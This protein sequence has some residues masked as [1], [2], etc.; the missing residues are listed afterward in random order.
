MKKAILVLPLLALLP[1]SAGTWEVGAFIGQQALKSGTSTYIG[2]ASTTTYSYDSDKKT[3]LGLRVGR[4]LVDLGPVLLSVT[5]GYQPDTNTRMN[6][7]YTTTGVPVTTVPGASKLGFRT[8]AA[9]SIN[10]STADFKSGHYS[11]GAMFNFKAF[12]SVGAGVEYRFEKMEID[13]D[14]TTYA[15]PWARVNAGIAI[16]SPILKPFIGIEAD[17]PLAS[18][19]LGINPS[20]EDILK[21]LGPKSQIGIYAGIRF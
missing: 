18:K 17:F 19:S 7:D 10:A 4:S 2:T 13:E 15:R 1:L 12:I 3:I 14:K 8:P 9:A 16:P 5:A 6:F 20:S 21:Y 11:V